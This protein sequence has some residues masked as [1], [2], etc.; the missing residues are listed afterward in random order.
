M[1]VIGL[2]CLGY[3]GPLEDALR[4]ATGK[5]V[6]LARRALAE[7]DCGGPAGGGQL[8]NSRGGLPDGYQP[9][10][11]VACGTDARSNP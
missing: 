7:A 4:R 6:V 2:N 10:E 9:A 5:P 3:N 1:D 11:L 8:T